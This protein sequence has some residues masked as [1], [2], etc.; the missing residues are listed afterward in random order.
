MQRVKSGRHF[1]TYYGALS[2]PID[3]V[4]G[5]VAGGTA[6][7]CRREALIVVSWGRTVEA[8]RATSTS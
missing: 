2:R 7:I 4:R 1:D 6:L 5:D 8:L 3:A